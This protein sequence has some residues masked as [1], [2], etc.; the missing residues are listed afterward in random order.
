MKILTVD[1]EEWFH[2]LDIPEIRDPRSWDQFESRI[3][4]N[5]DVLLELFVKHDVRATFFCLGWIAERFPYL[6]RRIDSMGHHIGSHSYFHSLVYK[7]TPIQFREETINSIRNIED[8]IGKKVNAYRAPGFSITKESLWALDIL[9]SEGVCYDSSVMPHK[10]S[11]GGIPKFGHLDPFRI[12]LVGGIMR[13]FPMSVRNFRIFTLPF[14]GGGYFRILPRLMLRRFFDSSDYVMTYF[15]PR[16]I[17]PGQPPIPMRLGRRF[18]SYVGLRSC[19]TK[20]D[21]LLSQYKFFDME[22]AGK[23]INWDV[24]PLIKI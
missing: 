10:H 9:M 5:V 24:T 19:L 4:R 23:L 6:I 17:D 18:R 8:L 16:D 11:H 1:L 20:L 2:I 14:S 12:E 21:F 22:T 13:E 3:E 7:Q 15:H